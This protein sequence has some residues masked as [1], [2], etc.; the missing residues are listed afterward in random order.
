MSNSDSQPEE[1]TYRLR[2]APELDQL[3]LEIPCSAIPALC[4][5][6]VKFLRYLGYCILGMDGVIKQTLDDEGISDDDLLDA[7]EYHFVRSGANDGDDDILAHAVDPEAMTYSDASQTTDARH[8]SRLIVAE[9]DVSC[10]FTNTAASMSRGIHIV[11]W[12]KGDAWLKQILETRFPE[13]GEDIQNLTSTDDIRNGMLVSNNL[14]PMLEHKKMVVLKTPNL[15][16]DRKDIPARTNHGSNLFGDVKHCENPCYTLQWMRG[17]EQERE[18]VSNNSDAAFKKHSRKSKPSPLL[19]H[20]NYGVAAL[21]WWGRGKEQLL[22]G[23]IRPARPIPAPLGPSGST[24][25]ELD[26]ARA[27]FSRPTGGSGS[28]T[29]AKAIDIDTPPQSQ[30]EQIVLTLWANTPTARRRRAE[31]KAERAKRIVDW[32]RNVSRAPET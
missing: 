6:P 5:R 1:K 28:N 20:Y 17:D 19:L 15:I 22:I 25:G 3:Y 18:S 32:Q 11:P 26:S 13:Q 16:L 29:E 10:V 12:S 4:L 7:G 31:Q 24:T 27:K 23:R 21:K 8:K 14:H 9:R 30:A 2:L